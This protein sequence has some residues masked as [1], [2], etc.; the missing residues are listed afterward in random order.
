MERLSK[1]RWC[2]LGCLIIILLFAAGSVFLPGRLTNVVKW[3]ADSES[4]CELRA[5]SQPGTMPEDR[6]TEMVVES[7]MI[8]QVSYQPV[9]ILK[10][11]E[12]EIYLP[13]S[14]GTA[15]ASAIGVVLEGIDMP[16]PLTPDLL[17]SIINGM[18]AQVNHIVINDLRDQIFY[19]NIVLNSDW[20]E[21]KIDARPSDAI[22]VALRVRA[23]IYVAEAVLDKAGI[24]PEHETGKY[25]VRH[26]SQLAVLSASRGGLKPPNS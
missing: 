22:A 10:Q 3:L 13:I 12:G 6:L 26:Y 23:P 14:I 4:A 9:V 8:S 20:Q 25:T 2:L 24:L 21:L 19:A 16:R 15:E 17:C 18:D 5:F 7:I 11:L 1:T